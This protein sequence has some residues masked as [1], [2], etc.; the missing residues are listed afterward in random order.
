VKLLPCPFCGGQEMQAL[1]VGDFYCVECES[2]R[3]RGQMHAVQVIAMGRWNR[4]T[5]TAPPEPPTETWCQRCDGLVTDAPVVEYAGATPPPLCRCAGPRRKTPAAT[6]GTAPIPPSEECRGECSR[7]SCAICWSR[8]G[9][10]RG[11]E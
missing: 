11:D 1:R 4:R 6:P 5:P 8:A 9:T 10:P 3:S 2:C 7:D